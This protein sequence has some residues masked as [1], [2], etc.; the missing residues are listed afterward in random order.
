MRILLII[1]GMLIS[2]TLLAQKNIKEAYI[3]T[4]AGDT[5]NGYIEIK[6]WGMNP[7]KILFKQ[8]PEESGTWYD[9]YDIKEFGMGGEVWEGGYVDIEVSARDEKNLSTDPNLFI[10]QDLVFLQ[11]I[12]KGSKSLYVY[13]KSVSENFYIKEGDEFVLLVYKAYK[14]VYERKPHSTPTT[15]STGQPDSIV[16]NRQFALQLARYFSGCPAIFSD[17]NKIQYRHRD[18]EKIF[19]EYYR[20]RN[21]AFRIF[22][23]VKN[24][25]F[26]WGLTI[27][28]AWSSLKFDDNGLSKYDFDY[29][30]FGLILELKRPI[31]LPNWSLF[32]EFTAFNPYVA[33]ASREYDMGN[34]HMKEKKVYSY[35]S[36]KMVN[37]IRYYYPVNKFNFFANAGLSTEF[38][39]GRWSKTTTS[40]ILGED[41][42]HTESHGDKFTAVRLSTGLG[43]N[44]WKLGAEFRWEPLTHRKTIGKTSS[45]IL[46]FHF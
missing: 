45:V 27:G 31:S 20:C 28:K 2:M 30:P 36:F 17:L 1:A 15:W 16:T 32:N 44:F 39:Y 41:V 4:L 43:V 46:S 10:E 24:V 35:D 5:V 11:A 7:S 21:E 23:P 38:F 33:R 29:Y 13:R 25:S 37:M 26:N 19:I 22:D 40:Q 3:I 14:I 42:E 12:I 9:P 18:L 6:N 34:F 8:S